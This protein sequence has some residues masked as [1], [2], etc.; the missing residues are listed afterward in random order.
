MVRQSL[1]AFAGMD[2]EAAVEVLPKDAEVDREYEG[3]VC[4]CITHMMED[5]RSMG[6]MLNLLWSLKAL[7]RSG[8]HATNIGEYIIYLVQARM[9][10]TPA[11][12]IWKSRW[13]PEN[14]ASTRNR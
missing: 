4:Q 3:V 7:E 5:S 2:I 6:Y 14:R 10:A 12:R 13:R 8:D 1:D 11:S 9:S